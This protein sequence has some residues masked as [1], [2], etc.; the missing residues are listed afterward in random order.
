MKAS[1][2]IIGSGPAALMA[3][4]WATKNSSHHQVHIFEKK[5]ALGRKLL[6][7]GSSGLNISHAL[8]AD[9]TMDRFARQYSGFRFEAWEK[10]FTDYSIQDWIQWIEHDLHLETFVGTSNRYFVREMKAAGLLKKWTDLLKSR[11]VQFHTQHEWI[12]TKTTVDP[13]NVLLTFQAPEGQ[14]TV[15][16]NCVAYFLGG[17]SWE[18]VTPAWLQQFQQMG[19]HV[20]PFEPSNVGYEVK[21]SPGLLAEAEG[22]PL[23]KI[24]LNTLKGSK[25]GELVIT[26]HGLEGTPVYFVGTTG[27]ADLDLLPDFTLD[28]IIQLLTNSTE[29]FSVLRRVKKFLPLSPAAQSLIFHHGP[30][31]AKNSISEMAQA[32]KKFQIELKGPRPLIEAISS[33][34][35]VSLNEVDDQL[36]LIKYPNQ[37]CG[38]EML[39]WDAPTGGFLIQACVS[40]GALIGKQL[41]S[42][43]DE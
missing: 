1:I 21:W 7:A 39:D 4:T 13:A 32:I 37:F 29:N 10:F 14:I 5:S 26:Q 41:A 23:K 19:I 33:K 9:F 16:S 31:S 43:M 40:Q 35:G 27:I 22:L 34:G 18:S 15:E 11:G 17:G 2:A 6:I 38:G 30:S 25:M 28:Q 20:H 8:N 42:L 12:S 36:K 3:A 24:V